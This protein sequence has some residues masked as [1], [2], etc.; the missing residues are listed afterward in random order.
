MDN[1]FKQPNCDRCGQSLKNGRMMSMF[2]TDCLCPDCIEAE[3]RHPDYPQA[4]AAD[5]AAICSGN[6]NFKGMGNKHQKNDC[7][8]K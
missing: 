2:S 7:E 8:K 5:H 1:F 3:R 4:V 6:F